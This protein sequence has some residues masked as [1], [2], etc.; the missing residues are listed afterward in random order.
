MT[1]TEVLVDGERRRV[2][3]VVSMD[4]FAVEL[5]RRAAAGHA[6]DD[7]RRGRLARAA[8]PASRSTITYELASQDRDRR[9]RGRA[10]STPALIR[11]RARAIV[12]GR[13]AWIH[14]AG[15]YQRGTKISR[16][17]CSTASRI[18]VDDERGSTTRRSPRPP[19]PAALREA[20]RLDEAR[21]DGVHRDPARA[22]AR[23][24]SSARTRAARASTPSTGPS[25]TRA[26]D[27]DDVDDVRARAEPGEEGAQAPDRAEVVR[28]R[29]PPRSARGRCRGTLPRAGDPRVV[30]EQV[31][32]RVALE[33]A[34]GDR[35][36]R[37]AVADVARPRARRPRAPAGARARRRA[38]RPA[39][40]SRQSA[41]PI[42]DEAP[43]TTATRIAPT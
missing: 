40:S 2:V 35:L 37:V 21:V 30:H 31:D 34:R 24:R 4:A 17:S 19:E 3:G 6:G 43:V 27:R 15:R 10:G 11:P 20:G 41:A 26:R 33:H 9:E 32:P 1:G 16:R 22:R 36:D 7:R 14:A 18:R 12:P 38:S 23:S 25:A 5:D 28:A 39:R 29:R 8:T 42:P 13:S